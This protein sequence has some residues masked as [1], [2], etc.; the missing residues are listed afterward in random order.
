MEYL[1]FVYIVVSCI[2]CSAAGARRRRPNI[3]VVVG[4]DIGWSDIGYTGVG[5]IPTPNI[6]AI[7]S[8]GVRL[9]SHYVHPTCTPSRAS[10]LTGRYSYNTGLSFAIFPGSPA[11]LDPNITT[12]PQILRRSNYST[13]MSGKWHIGFSRQ[14]QI[15]TGRGFEKW[16]G[17]FV[18]NFDV[19]TKQTYELPW[20]HLAVDWGEFY[21]NKTA[22]HFVDPRHVTEAITSN[23]ID[24]MH[25]YKAAQEEEEGRDDPMFLYVAYTAAHSPLQPMKRHMSHCQH[26]PHLWRRRFC[27]L[28][29]G[30]DEG[31][32]NITDAALDILGDDTVMVFLSDNGGSPWFGGI[33]APF[34]GGKTSAFEGGVHVPAFAVDF[35]PDKRY[36]GQGGREFDG[37]VHVSDW[38]PTL[39]SIA[40]IPKEE[41]PS[42]LDGMDQSKVLA[43]G[44]EGIRNEVIMELISSEEGI[45]EDGMIA[46]R[47]GDLKIVD[48]L[49]R[50]KHWYSEPRKDRLNTTDDT[51]VSIIGETILRFFESIFNPAAFD[52]SH[53][54]I[55]HGLVMNAFS[56]R[57][58]I[59]L[60]NI[61]EDPSETRSISQ[62]RPDLFASMMDRM[63][64]LLKTKRPQEHVWMELPPLKREQSWMPGDCSAAPSIKPEHCR[65]LS[66]FAPDDV[67]P[68]K[69]DLQNGKKHVVVVAKELVGMIAS[70]FIILL[71]FV[72]IFIFAVCRRVSKN[73]PRF[74]R[75]VGSHYSIH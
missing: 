69:G 16:I 56:S 9:T 32:K 71:T 55:A 48:G 8:K 12:L 40:G 15:P 37:L 43:S 20:V 25:D 39:A 30:L 59:L 23:A 57:E 49:V 38:L 35:S 54:V 68:L 41:L 72:A 17:C 21:E 42:Q 36:F 31:V 22:R 27:G 44:G 46:F 70:S 58:E 3:I 50:E 60:F 63:G 53:H 5:N 65:F 29:V 14:S 34:R 45:F 64:E 18:C 13:Y 61:T 73:H 62:E 28:V 10:L 19:H 33:N 74:S 51:M 2:C 52:T 1:K 24:M 66:T 7:S 11:G 75:L 4:D 26:I 47:R 67:D 6:D